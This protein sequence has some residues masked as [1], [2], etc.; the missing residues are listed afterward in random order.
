MNVRRLV[1]IVGA[2]VFADTLFYSVI[3]P[4]LPQLSHQL[5]MS[6]AAAGVMTAGYPAGMLVASLPGGM[7]AMRVGPRFTVCV[8]L[9]LMV[10]STLAFGLLHAAVPLDL[11]RFI[12]GVGGACSWAGGL[13]WL[14]AATPVEQR[15]AMMGKSLGASIAGGLFGPAVGALASAIGRAVMFSGLAAIALALIALT[16]TLPERRPAETQR[17]DVLKGVFARRDFRASMWLM[18]L[19]AIVSGL[20][21]VLV[22]LRM[23]ALGSGAGLIGATFLA[24]A[25]VEA[26]VSPLV[27]HMSDRRGRMVP[28]RL[29]LGAIAIALACF[30]LPRSGAVFAVTIV[31]TVM[32]LGTFWAPAMALVSDLAED[33]GIDQALAA[34]L[35]NLAWAAGQIVG[36]AG[37]GAVSKSFGDAVPTAACAVLCVLTL[38]SISRRRRPQLQKVG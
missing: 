38:A 21:N 16:C 32:L 2:V 33:L 6:K 15:G 12:E 14:V 11:A 10:I 8:G 20:I 25:A 30:M 28:I 31:I 18:A 7:L 9:A 27:G 19:P 34:A 22:P 24:G 3:A 26:L 4:L 1:W 23:H 35:M 17:L 13:A 29:G 5:H 36:S 37:G